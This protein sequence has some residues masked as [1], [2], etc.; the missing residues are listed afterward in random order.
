M[1]VKGTGVARQNGDNWCPLWFS[2]EHLIS[3]AGTTGGNQG[4]GRG[5]DA[6]H[7]LNQALPIPPVS[8]AMGVIG[9]SPD[10]SAICCG[11]IGA[12]R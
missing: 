12:W 1:I 3:W 4:A 6:T 2:G 7:Q 8:G 10:V 11:G 5:Q 9:Y